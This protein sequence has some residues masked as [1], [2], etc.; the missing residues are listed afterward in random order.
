MDDGDDGHYGHDDDDGHYGHDDDDD[1]HYGHDDDDDD[2]GHYGHDDDD[3]DDDDGGNS[4]RR[5]HITPVPGS[6]TKS[7]LV[8]LCIL[9]FVHSSILHIPKRWNPHQA[10]VSCQPTPSSSSTGIVQRSEKWVPPIV[11]TIPKTNSP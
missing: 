7:I 6:M 1:G 8:I 5:T 4:L 10:N 3:D 2:D 9:C 11:A